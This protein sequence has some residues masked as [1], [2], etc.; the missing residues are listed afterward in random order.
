MI[1]VTYGELEIQSRVHSPSEKSIV[2]ALFKV[3]LIIFFISNSFQEFVNDIS[4]LTSLSTDHSL[5]HLC[6]KSTNT[7][8]TMDFG[9]LTVL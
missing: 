3:G 8:K 1:F 6:Q 2:Q 9:N 5:V 4:I 7:H